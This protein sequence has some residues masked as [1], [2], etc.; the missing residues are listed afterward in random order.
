MSLSTREYTAF[1]GFD[2]GKHSI[3]VHDLETGTTQEIDNTA[4]AIGGYVDSLP[5]SCFAVCEATG[6]YEAV[7][8]RQLLKAGI[9]CHRADAVK[10]KAFIR[11]FG[12]LAK[13]DAVDAR[14]LAAYGRERCQQLPLYAPPQAEQAKLQALVLRRADLVAL[15]VAETNR[16]KAPNS[17]TVA[18]FIKPV[19]KAITT[20]IKAVE[21]E[22]QVL[23]DACEQMG[24]QVSVMRTVKGVGPTTAT[25]LL[26]LMPELGTLTRRQAAALAGCAPY[27]NDSGARKGYRRTK[28]GRRD[29]RASLFMAAL[30]AARHKGPL[31]DF[32]G[33]LIRRGKKPIVAITA[34]MRKIIVI[35]NAKLRDLALANQTQLS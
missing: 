14:A 13:T 19:L 32:Y 4:G 18:R 26:A 9:A 5:A 33:T 3:T 22:I 27:P 11:S 8:L 15:K 6:G 31:K 21:K 25:T 7:L 10:V 2:V 12:T 20:Q 24:Q 29:V 23:L 16:L 35:L 17:D 34:L 1:V 30:S 28:G